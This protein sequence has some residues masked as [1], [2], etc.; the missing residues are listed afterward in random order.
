MKIKRLFVSSEVVP[1]AKTGG[2]ADVSSALPKAFKE[3]GEDVKVVMPRYYCI[4]RDNLEKLPMPLGVDMGY[5]GQLWAGVYKSYLPNSNVEIYFIDYELFF[6]RDGLYNQNNIDYDD[7][8]IRFIFF[9]KAALQLAKALNFQPD[10]IHTNDWH[11]ASIPI[12]LK[13]SMQNDPF[14]NKTSTIL[15]I[16]NLEHQG[17]FSKRVIELLNISWDYF[18]PEILEVYDGVNLLKGGI[19]FADAITTVSKKYAQEIQT[20]EYGFGLDEHIKAHSYKLKGIL[21]GVDYSEWNPKIDPYIAKNYDLEN[22]EDKIECKRDL[23]KYFN[24]P[25]RDDVALIG[26]IGRFAKQKGIE[27]IASC[28][29]GFLDLDIQIVMLGSGEEWAQNLFSQTAFSNRDKFACYIGYNNPLAHKIE[30]GCNIFLMP[31]L[32]EPCGLNQIYSLRY[33]TLPLVRATGG[34]DDTIENYNPNTKE[35]V[36]FKFYDATPNALYNTLKWAI[37]TYYNNKEDFKLMQKRAIQKRYS[38]IDSAK[39]YQEISKKILKG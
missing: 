27:L 21:N 19:Y 10:I 7:N 35:G 12:L 8:D 15:T 28:L 37:D 36:G 3:L 34:L 30:A 17:V 6:G 2:L 29:R 23:Q 22:I 25:Q 14:F 13:T 11:T 20:P 16:H 39:E 24:L 31:S 18:K 32:F 4:N 38:W 1:F 26:F 9:S 33:A 5:M